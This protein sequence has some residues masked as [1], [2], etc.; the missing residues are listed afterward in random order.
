ML[1]ESEH[2]VGN[3]DPPKLRAAC[4]NCRQSKV[5]CNLSGKDTCIR[6]LRHGLPCRYRVANRSGKPKG[7]KNRATLR[8]LGQLQDDKKPTISTSGWTD[9]AG[10]GQSHR[11]SY[12]A[13]PGVD[14]MSPQD[15]SPTSQ[16][17]SPDS[18]G[19]NMTDPTLLTD[20]I[21][22]YPPLGETLPSAAPIFNPTSMSPTFLQKEFITKGFTSCPLAVH[23]PNTLQ[24]CECS[25]ALI[26]HG[27]RLRHM[28]VDSIHLRLDQMLQGIKIALSVC[29]GFLQCPNCHKDNTNLLL[30]VSILEITLQLFEY[31]IRY[32][33]SSPSTGDHSMIVGY[34][35]YE[36]SAD[37]TRRIRRFLVRGRLLQGKEVLG[38][39][40]E[41]VEM[42]RQMSPDLR[43]LSG[44]DGLE[45][46]WLQT[47]L[48]GYEGTVETW[49]QAMS[50]SMCST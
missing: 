43:D 14:T 17:N 2:A 38:L 41:A 47:I 10:K 5:K 21:V 33:F 40:K 9:A 19:A 42:S 20:P 28:L 1:A 30:S 23:I 4:E 25:S 12:D 34:G 11:L 32:E 7:S 48:M 24:P 15:T 45:G 8:K 50:D 16:S 22:E 44:T 26:Y 27:N 3:G 39:L 6:C 18:Q 13:D 49:L 36:M 37:E 35:E 46:E 29:R 31:C